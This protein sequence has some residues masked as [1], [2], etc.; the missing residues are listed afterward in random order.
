MDNKQLA[1]FEADG[2]VMV[3]ALLDRE[4]VAGLLASARSDQ[5]LASE[6]YTR[7]DA[8]GG[9]SKLSL[10]NELDNNCPYTALVRSQRV[11]G[12]MAALLGD[13]VYHYHHK[14]ML[15]EPRVGGAWEWHQDYGYWYNFG[16][17]FPD[18]ASCLIAVDRATRAN[19]CLQVLRGSHKMG[20]VDHQAT[21][22]QTGADPLRV[23]AALERFEHLYC[24]MEPG[25]GLF[26]HANLLHCS[27][28]NE[29]E[30]PRWS[31]ICCYNTR[32]NDPIV[33]GGRHPN[34][35]P[36]EIWPDDRVREMLCSC[37]HGGVAA[38][39]SAAASSTAPELTARES[40]GP[41]KSPAN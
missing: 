3:R 37:Q 1:A 12:R 25:D 16:C 21:G 9:Q 6:A 29:S 18:M 24:E 26:F 41:E 13:E 5:A 36:L 7:K 10:R 33:R 4:E 39:G 2:F 38:S 22:E 30:H 32:H 31:L 35:S 17:L 27:S 34:Y 14:M 20:R 28:K 15:K 23:E 8:T 40:P 19:G 11:A